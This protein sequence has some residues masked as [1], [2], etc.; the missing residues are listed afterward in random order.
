VTERVKA[1]RV[2]R[3]AERESAYQPSTSN[4]TTAADSLMEL[5]VTMRST[6][7]DTDVD[8]PMG[9]VG[10]QLRV[11]ELQSTT[12]E[13]WQQ[14]WTASNEHFGLVYLTDDWGF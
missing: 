1:F 3:R 2:R 11:F 4:A 7:T 6:G 10:V 5:H 13:L 14:K 9:P 8:A 12:C